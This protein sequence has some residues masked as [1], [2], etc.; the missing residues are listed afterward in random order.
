MITVAYGEIEPGSSRKRSSPE[1]S[2][3][4]GQGKP[5]P[6][7]PSYWEAQ[8]V[9]IVGLRYPRQGDLTF[10][11]HRSLGRSQSSTCRPLV[12]PSGSLSFYPNDG[13][14]RGNSG[15][16]AVRSALPV[17]FRLLRRFVAMAPG[18]GYSQGPASM[19]ARV[20]PGGMVSVTGLPHRREMILAGAAGRGWMDR[21]A[22]S[23]R[24]ASG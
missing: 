23:S 9:T 3:L 5:G 13:K 6:S 10:V 20:L 14:R 7:G 2:R 11:N 17:N 4:P 22:S 21:G 18:S 8:S 12:E 19:S 16:L 1:T 15:G 24:Y